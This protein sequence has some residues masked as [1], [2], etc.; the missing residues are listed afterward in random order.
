MLQ[1]TNI[2]ISRY[3]NVYA[4]ISIR[5]IVIVQSTN[6]IDLLKDFT[7]LYVISSIDNITFSVAR[8][9][10][11]G[12]K[13]L[14]KAARAEEIEISSIDI[15]SQETQDGH[16]RW[17]NGTFIK[18][19]VLHTILALSVSAWI[20]VV[21]LQG[22]GYMAKLKYP[23]CESAFPSFKSDWR[24]LE[25]NV[26]NLLFNHPDCAYDGG[27][28]SEFNLIYPGCEVEDISLLGNGICDGSPY[29]SNLC[30]FDGGDCPIENVIKAKYPL[31]EKAAPSFSTNWTLVENEKCDMVRKNQYCFDVRVILLINCISS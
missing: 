11:F 14:V 29:D 5:L 4:Q 25:N 10:F 20:F 16:R 24:L 15:S 30:R 31:C 3:T 2:F 21:V 18:T 6:V 13:L 1:K 27:D 26:C 17:S 9:G 8:R 22:K 12:T 23:K 28:C 7:S 19:L